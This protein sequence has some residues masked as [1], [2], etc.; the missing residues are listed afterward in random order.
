MSHRQ[1]VLL[2][3]SVTSIF[4]QFSQ[5]EA[6]LL[7]DNTLGAESSVVTP[8]N[9]LEDRIDGGAMRGTNLFHSFKEFNI[10]NGRSVYF[11]NPSTIQNILTRVTGNNPSE[12]LGKLGVLGNANLF[13]INPKGIIF[14]QGASLDIKGSFVGSTASFIN[15]ADGNQ[16]SAVST[17]DKPLLTISA[18]IGLGMGNNP[19]EIRV[20]GNGHTFTSTTGIPFKDNNTTALEVKPGKTIA[21]IGGDIILEG[22]SLKANSG[23]I[24]L[25]SIGSGLVDFNLTPESLKFNYTKVETF[26]DIQLSEK[27]SLNANSLPMIHSQMENDMETN[28]IDAGSIQLQGRRISL[29]DGSIMLIENQGNIPEGSININATESLEILGR[30]LKDDNSSGLHSQALLTGKGGNITVSTKQLLVKDGAIISAMNYG[31]NSGG[32]IELKVS[33]SVKVIGFSGKDKDSSGIIANTFSSG[34]GGNINISTRQLTNLDGGIISSSTFNQ[35]NAG[36]LFINASESVAVIGMEPNLIQPSVLTSLTIG[37]GNGGNLTINTQQLTIKQ[38]GR[39]DASTL[40]NGAAGSITINASAKLE[41]SGFV[42]GSLNPSLIISS[43]SIEDETLQQKFN[44]PSIP[45]GN[46]GEITINTNQLNITDGA[47]L[48]VK[49]DGLGNAG[50]LTVKANYIN[51]DTQGSISAAT[52]TGEGGDIDL[53]AE[54]LLMRRNSNI[55]ATS[56]GTGNGGNI[57]IDTQVLTALENSDIQANSEGSFGGRVTI[58]S[59]AIFGTE[60]REFLTPESD[61]T[62]TSGLGAE[63]NGVVDINTIVTPT[64]TRLVEL[65]NN[66]T[67]SSQ[68]IAA[69]C[70]EIELNKF[71]IIG[72]GGLPESP[73]QLFAGDR[74]MVDLVDVVSTSENQNISP[75]STS[76][77][78]NSKKEIVEA[79]GWIVDTEGNILFVA[80]VP[81]VTPNSGGIGAADCHG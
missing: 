66:F 79:Q 42:G 7:P 81:G 57:T 15:F 80:E 30:N 11:N 16:F 51:I 65:P 67:D 40:S 14:G 47:L 3:L 19:G 49:N 35:G 36:N 8:I 5:V 28:L 64:N 37:S 39:V 1:V 63:F 24:E 46:S 29:S 59:K 78:N 9:L 6:Q 12:I 74:T 22:G 31:S 62:A 45:T 4:L 44:L 27:A 77:I 52:A 10:D 61:I 17:E 70:R 43:A 58:N 25:A 50:K 53:Q 75:D 38:G 2:S 54:N 13:L 73:N 55:S 72:R 68:K 41:L 32:N 18:P 21:L 69:T 23:K 56:A 20:Q 26:Q 48:T 60:F 33:D 76:E 71:T 34:N